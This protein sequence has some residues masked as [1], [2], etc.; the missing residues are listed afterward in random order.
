MSRPQNIYQ[1]VPSIKVGDEIFRTY[2]EAA[3]HAIIS[4]PEF[5]NDDR[6]GITNIANVLIKNRDQI[7]RILSFPSPRKPRTPKAKPEGK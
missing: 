2:E 6:E 4:L 1:Q 7:I 3:V 5:G